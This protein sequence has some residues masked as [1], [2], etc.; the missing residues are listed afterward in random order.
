MQI[1]KI[2]KANNRKKKIYEFDISIIF[3]YIFKLKKFD[4]SM[5]HSLQYYARYKKFII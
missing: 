5:L 1:R 4:Y 2:L 3:L